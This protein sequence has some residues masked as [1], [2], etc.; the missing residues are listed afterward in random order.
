MKIRAALDRGRT[1]DVVIRLTFEGGGGEDEIAAVGAYGN[2]PVRDAVACRCATDRRG[3]AVM[4]D[5]R[6]CAAI[7][8]RED[9]R[10][11]GAH[12]H[13]AQAAPN[14]DLG[15]DERALLTAGVIP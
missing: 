8:G 6:V 14:A 1:A 15:E 10:P 11:I 9:R 7:T 4:P 5:H 13:V 12:A 3:L 2:A